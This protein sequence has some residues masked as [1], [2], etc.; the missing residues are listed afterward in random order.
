MYKK[1]SNNEIIINEI[2]IDKVN[3][4]FGALILTS[5]FVFFGGNLLLLNKIAFYTSFKIA[6]NS[7]LI[8][9]IFYF[10]SFLFKNI[11]LALVSTYFILLAIVYFQSDIIFILYH[12]LESFSFLFFIYKFRINYNTL[13]SLILMSIS[14]TIIILGCLHSYTS[15]DMLNRISVGHVHQ[16][17]LFHSSISAMIKNY[18]IT[19]TGL[20]GLVETPNHALSHALIACVS[21]LT[22]VGVIEVYG[23]LPFVFFAPLLIFSVT[24]F[25]FTNIKKV[26]IYCF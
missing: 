3:L 15:F 14:S 22:G 5:L 11:P 10:L 1:I 21:L 24:F 2:P 8:L 6:I 18:H 4:R 16:D 23:V 17:T 12:L 25:L 9:L 19:S 7:T 20:N 13:N 26:L